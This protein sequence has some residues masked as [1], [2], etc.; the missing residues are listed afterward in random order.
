MIDCTKCGVSW[1]AK[2]FYYSKGKLQQPCKECRKDTSS[3]NYY[4]NQSTILE[5]RWKVYHAPETHEQKK[6]YFRDY[7][8]RNKPETITA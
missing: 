6:T 8:H 3:K 5:D 1:D 7:Y 4:N 2:G